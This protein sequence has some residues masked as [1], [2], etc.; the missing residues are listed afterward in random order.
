[1]KFMPGPFGHSP[2]VA[3]H[4]PAR[5]PRRPPARAAAEEADAVRHEFAT[6]EAPKLRFGISA[7]RI[8]I[9][10]ADVPTTVVDVEAIRGDLDDLKV[11]QHGRDI[12]IETRK[13]L[14]RNQRVRDPHPHAARRRRRREH[15]LGR[16]PRQRA[17]R[18]ASR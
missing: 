17:A 1:M 2:R 11:E 3:A 15:R 13:K 4:R 14:G 6:A 16:L 10:T 9:E 18:R 7:G 8:E 12:V 5:R